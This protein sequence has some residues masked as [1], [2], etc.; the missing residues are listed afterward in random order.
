MDRMRW[1]CNSDSIDCYA[2]AEWQMVQIFDD[3]F[4]GKVCATDIDFCVERRG[5]FLFFEFKHSGKAGKLDEGQR[6]MLEQLT[7]LNADR[8]KVIAF[9]VEIDR[10]SLEIMRYRKVQAG[11]V[12]DWVD[13]TPQMFLDIV[14]RWDAWARG[15]K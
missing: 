12:G 9:V 3:C 6:I 8:D 11:K 14:C 5:H 13:T 1:S 4:E 2:N 7:R 15:A 10:Y